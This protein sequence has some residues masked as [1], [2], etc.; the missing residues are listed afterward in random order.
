MLDHGLLQEWAIRR[1]RPL[2]EAWYAHLVDVE[3]WDAHNSRTL[4]DRSV[5]RICWLTPNLICSHV[6]ER[7]GMKKAALGLVLP[8]LGAV[9]LSFPTTALSSDQSVCTT[10]T[11]I[12]AIALD[13]TP[14][15]TKRPKIIVLRATLVVDGATSPQMRVGRQLM[16]EAA[17]S[18]LRWDAAYSEYR[19][20]A[21]QAVGQKNGRDRIMSLIGSLRRASQDARERVA[22]AEHALHA[23]GCHS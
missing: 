19:L 5:M 12:G 16:I 7:K 14:L 20:K 21:L 2:S 1:G 22:L 15:S 8:V 3:G 23:G 18:V 4:A 11:K 6:T 10:A 9:A 13:K 17:G